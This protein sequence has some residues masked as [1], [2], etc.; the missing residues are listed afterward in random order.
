[1]RARLRAAVALALAVGPLTACTGDPTGPTGETIRVGVVVALSG[2]YRAV[3]EDLR[4]GFQLYLS[5]HQNRL[6]GRPVEVAVVDEA[7]GEA[8]LVR[9]VT[10]LLGD[11]RLMAITGVT[12]AETT[13]T[14]APL[15][16]DRHLPLVGS[17]GRPA[18][19]DL[20]AVWNTELPARRSR[21]WP[22]RSTSSPV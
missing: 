20:T 5:T 19:A 18:V 2:P 15:L 1:M 13:A 4:D 12:S 9:Q 3:G 6:G 10:S 8:E 17:N 11:P 14:L 22:S 16:R 7:A 21:A